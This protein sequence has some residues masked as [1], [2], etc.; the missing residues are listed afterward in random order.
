MFQKLSDNVQA[1]STALKRQVLTDNDQSIDKIYDEEA[2][3]FVRF[4]SFVCILIGDCFC[5]FSSS[6]K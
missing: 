2:K 6:G 3:K 1:I 5:S 4:W